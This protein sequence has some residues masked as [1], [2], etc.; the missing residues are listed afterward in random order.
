MFL[1]IA[2]KSG[3]CSHC[4]GE[5]DEACEGLYFRSCNHEIHQII[6]PWMHHGTVFRVAFYERAGCEAYRVGSD[7]CQGNQGRLDGIFLSP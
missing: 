4:H 1:K 6:F 7:Q 3:R 5:N 2:D